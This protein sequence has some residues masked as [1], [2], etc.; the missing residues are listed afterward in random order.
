MQLKDKLIIV[1]GHKAAVHYIL[2][3][4]HK[5]TFGDIPATGNKIQVMSSDMFE[6]D[7]QGLVSK[8]TTITKLDDLKAQ[9]KG[10]QQTATFDDVQPLNN[11]EKGDDYVRQLRE[12]AAQFHKNFN[13][14]EVK[15]NAEL[16]A[17]TFQVNGQVISDF[18]SF[19]AGVKQLQ[20]FLPDMQIKD[21]HRL[22]EGHRAAV[23][24]TTYG[25]HKGDF[26]APDGSVIK[27]SGKQ[28]AVKGLE[29]MTFNNEGLLEELIIISNQ[30]DLLAQLSN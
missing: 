13:A 18:E 3:A 21:H 6:F 8:L 10:G 30:D 26:N 22:V 17:P 14:G 5:G 25:T 28:I 16:F 1:D 9:V 27:A 7:D 24:Y 2:Q 20:A 4:E 23:Q 15:K 12:T 19:F 29:F 11:E